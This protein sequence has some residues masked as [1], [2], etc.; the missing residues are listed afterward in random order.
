M[1]IEE[2]GE[3]FMMVFPLSFSSY[4][5]SLSAP[6]LLVTTSDFS[7]AGANLFFVFIFFSTSTLVVPPSTF[8]VSPSRFRSVVSV[9]SI[10]L[11]FAVVK[12]DEFARASR[13]RLV[14]LG[15]VAG[16]FAAIQEVEGAEEEFGGVAAG[17]GAGGDRRRSDERRR[18]AQVGDWRRSSDAPPSGA[19]ARKPR[20]LGGGGGGGGGDGE[21]A[22]EII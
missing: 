7:F 10:F 11:F 1:E 17:G 18:S 13:P 6:S 16:G 4:L 2:E 5:L 20:R 15:R 21:R 12:E 8:G 14:R 19:S 9:L 3:A 22:K